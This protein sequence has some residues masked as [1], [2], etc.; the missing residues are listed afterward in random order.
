M[1]WFPYLFDGIGTIKD[2]EV[3]LDID[4]YITSIVQPSR[5]VP[6]VIIQPLKEELSRMEK[7]SDSQT[8]YKWSNQ[9]VSQSS[10]S[11]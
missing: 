6:K 11:P 8:G 7:L 9:L 2:A 10:A 5:K 3:K 1:E 4:P